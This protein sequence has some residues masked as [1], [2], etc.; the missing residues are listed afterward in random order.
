MKDVGVGSPLGPGAVDEVGVAVAVGEGLAVG[1]LDA[2]GELEVLGDGEAVGVCEVVGVGLGD[3]ATMTLHV[4]LDVHDAG[5]A[6]ATVDAPTDTDA[7]AAKSG[8]QLGADTCTPVGFAVQV[9]FQ[10]E[11][12]LFDGIAS[13]TDQ[14]FTAELELLVIVADTV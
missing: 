3:P 14:F 4:M 9:A 12:T 1:V 13:T 10:P 11:L 7:P 6:L 5:L 8:A 2:L